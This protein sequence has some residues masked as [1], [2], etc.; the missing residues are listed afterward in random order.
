MDVNKK[1]EIILW[2]TGLVSCY[3]ICSI[4][5]KYIKAKELPR[6]QF[7]WNDPGYM[8]ACIFLIIAPIFIITGLLFVSLRTRNK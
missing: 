6:D 7:L 2:T 1:Q 4:I 3:W 8:I 5:F